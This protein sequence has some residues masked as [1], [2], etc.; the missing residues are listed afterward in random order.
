MVFSCVR[1][2]VWRRAPASN[3]KSLETDSRRPDLET[4]TKDKLFFHYLEKTATRAGEVSRFLTTRLQSESLMSV[5]LSPKQ[6][7][8]SL[9]SLDKG[10]ER[11]HLLLHQGGTVCGTTGN[12]TSTSCAPGYMKECLSLQR[13]TRLHRHRQTRR[14]RSQFLFSTT[15]TT[16]RDSRVSS[17][18]CLRRFSPCI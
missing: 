12:C 8:Y 4:S 3:D 18:L 1:L 7:I 11:R 9:R 2:I 6:C 16:P 5:Y 15:M 17:W 13:L 14:H 10:R